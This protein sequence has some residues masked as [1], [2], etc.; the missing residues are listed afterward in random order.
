MFAMTTEQYSLGWYWAHQPQDA[1]EF[2]VVVRFQVAAHPKQVNDPVLD[3][4]GA[5][6]LT[7]Q[8]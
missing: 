4:Y 2:Q 8:K 3:M 1:Y 5:G 7:T 6:K